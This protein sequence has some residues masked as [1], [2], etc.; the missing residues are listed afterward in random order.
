MGKKIEHRLITVNGREMIVLDPTDFERLDAARRQIGARQASIAWLRQQ[1]E[2]ANT[3]LAELET[4]LTKAHHQPD[5]PCHEA[6]APS[7]P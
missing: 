7:A 6:T 5:C 2:A 1:L 4:E 3:R